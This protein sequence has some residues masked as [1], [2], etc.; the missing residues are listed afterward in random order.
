MIVPVRLLGSDIPTS[1]AGNVDRIAFDGEHSVRIRPPV[2]LQP[3]VGIGHVLAVEGTDNLVD[4]GDGVGRLNVVV[5]V[6][7]SGHE[8]DKSK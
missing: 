3:R 8:I 6:G 7:R 5:R 1:L 4:G 2:L